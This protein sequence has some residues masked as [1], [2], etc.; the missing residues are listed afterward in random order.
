MINLDNEYSIIEDS[1]GN[2]VLK[3]DKNNI[4][5]LILDTDIKE[6]ITF[7]GNSEKDVENMNKVTNEYLDK[8]Y[9][10]FENEEVKYRVGGLK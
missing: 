7:N 4:F 6:V 3:N 1:I 10:Y 9:F 8:K 5:V 2:L